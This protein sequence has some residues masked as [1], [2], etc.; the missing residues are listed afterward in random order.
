MCAWV[1]N[2]ALRLLPG[3]HGLYLHLRAGFDRLIR[4]SLALTFI[5][6]LYVPRVH[7]LSTIKA[8]NTVSTARR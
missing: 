3:L 2:V 7:E 5:P 6:L 1:R 4:F 8:A